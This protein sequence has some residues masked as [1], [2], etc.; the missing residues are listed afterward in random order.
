MH[1]LEH[2]ETLLLRLFSMGRTAS[3]ELRQILDVMTRIL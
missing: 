2:A 1:S 3:W